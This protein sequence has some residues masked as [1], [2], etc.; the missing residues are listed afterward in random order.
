MVVEN[1]LLLAKAE[2][3]FDEQELKILEIAAWFHDAGFVNCYNE[4]EEESCNI[5]R[6]FLPDLG[7]SDSE[8][9]KICTLIRATKVPQTPKDYLSEIL[10][11]AD[12]YYLGSSSF[13]EISEKLKQEWLF[14]GIIQNDE[15][16]AERQLKFLNIHQYFTE[17]AKK[18]R[19]P[20]KKKIIEELSKEKHR[21]LSA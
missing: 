20:G 14:Y 21:Q 3:V 17:T 9:E 16:F 8:V 18:E 11:D 4:H 12:L 19:E 15:A 5:V 13:F 10:C 2:K 1:S 7:A 6:K